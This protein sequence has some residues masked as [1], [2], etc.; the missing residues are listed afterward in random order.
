MQDHDLKLEGHADHPFEPTTEITIR[1]VLHG[2]MK[3]IRAILLA[4]KMTQGAMRA[5]DRFPDMLMAKDLQVTINGAPHPEL[6]LF[7]QSR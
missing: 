7:A 1:L 4:D 2:D 3:S 5:Y 6:A